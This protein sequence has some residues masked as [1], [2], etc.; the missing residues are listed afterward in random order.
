LRYNEP[1][2]STNFTLTLTGPSGLVAGSTSL[3]PDLRLLVFTPE[4]RLLP[5]TTYRLTVD[6]VRDLAGNLAL[7]QPFTSTFNTLDTLG[8]TISALRLAD[9]QTPV[10]GATVQLEAVLAAPEFAATVRFTADIN[11]TGIRPIG[12]AAFAPYRVSVK[13]PDS[14][15]VVFRAIA[16]DRFG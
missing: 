3:G 13:L 5:N 1:I 4:A 16:T 8:P 6:G 2:R 7:N 11:A 14:R 10:T 9:N 12:A 15:R